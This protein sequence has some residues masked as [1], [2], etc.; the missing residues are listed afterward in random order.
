MQSKSVARPSGK[1]YVDIISCVPLLPLGCNLWWLKDTEGLLVITS[2]DSDVFV[3]CSVAYAIVVSPKTY[4][5]YRISR[6]VYLKEIKIM[7]K[8][9]GQCRSP[10][11]RIPLSTS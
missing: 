2:K 11:M 1:C 10:Y 8:E 9:L 3:V 5:I 4:L 6:T 7:K